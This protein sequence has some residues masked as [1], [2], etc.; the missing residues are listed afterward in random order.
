MVEHAQHVEPSSQRSRARALAWLIFS[1]PW[2]MVEEPS[3]VVVHL[4]S[5]CRTPRSLSGFV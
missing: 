1:W 3:V 4:L 5:A 2:W